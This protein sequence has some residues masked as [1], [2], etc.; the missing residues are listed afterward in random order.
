M[1]PNIG[2]SDEQREGVVNILN[3]LL[4]D[5][6]LLYTKTRNYH[7]NVFGPQFNDLHKFLERQYEELEEVVDQ[8]AE[9]ARSLGGFAFGTMT[10]FVQHTRLKEQP[11]QYPDARRMLSNLLADHESL[12]RQ[13]RVDSQTCDERFHDLGT[14][15]FLIGLMERHEKTAWMFRAFLE[16]EPV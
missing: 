4:S 3:A 12:I 13:L 6:Y 7:W 15:D 11:G 14:N 1:K 2:L 8:V 16:G 9:R 10:E 5:E